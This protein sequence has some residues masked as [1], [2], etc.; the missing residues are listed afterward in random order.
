MSPTRFHMASLICGLAAS[1][2]MAPG[3]IAAA[4]KKTSSKPVAAKIEKTPKTAKSAKRK[5]PVPEANPSATTTAKARTPEL[6]TAL[7]SDLKAKLSL[8]GA[9]R[10]ALAEQLH[11]QL[12]KHPLAAR[13]EAMV[14]ATL[15]ALH[16]SDEGTRAAAL[17]LLLQAGTLWPALSEQPAA[18]EIWSAFA[19]AF[20]D[21]KSSDELVLRQAALTLDAGSLPSGADDGLIFYTGYGL[22]MQGKLNEAR[23]R[24]SRLPLESA[25]YRR[26]KFLEAQIAVQKDLVDGALEALEV[27][28]SFAPT[29]AEK[30]AFDKASIARL[31]ELAVL[32]RAR[33]LYERG[34]FLASLANY[35]SLSQDSPFFQDTLWEQG[36]AFFMA[37]YPNRALGAEYAATSPFFQGY[38]TP[39]AHFLNSITYYWVCDFRNAKSE[40]AKF[41]THARAEGDALRTMSAESGALKGEA[42]LNRYARLFGDAK[43]GV[44]SSNLGVGPKAA[45][46]LL[47]KRNLE[48]LHAT[49]KGLQKERAGFE[50]KTAMKAGKERVLGAMTQFEDL[51]R[52]TLGSQVRDQLAAMNYDFERA[53]SQARLLHLEILTAQKDSLLDKE[54]SVVGQEFLGE[55]KDFFEQ[56]AAGPKQW[57]FDKKEFWYDELGSYVFDVKSQCG[58]AAALSKK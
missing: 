9:K 30:G 55:E 37:G 20:E 10:R 29:E 50:E 31:R 47:A 14:L 5:Q 39:D 34:D 2:L 35:R 16:A 25:H 18:A 33:L 36:W 4:T 45:R 8:S 57:D 7:F 48:D 43:A 12:N 32:N 53:L 40:L 54:R 56:V 46:S 38:F 49:L 41:V 24:L 42:L 22:F 28:A 13:D 27:V 3:A 6:Q 19:K 11:A 51:V 1:A 26:G 44:S 21:R 52:R 15:A 58:G 17:P 23:D